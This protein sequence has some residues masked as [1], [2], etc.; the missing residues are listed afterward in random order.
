M[1]KG[2]RVSFYAYPAHVRQV[3]EWLISAYKPTTTIIGGDARAYIDGR[4]A[5]IIGQWLLDQLSASRQFKQRPIGIIL[6]RAA[7]KWLARNLPSWKRFS[8][9]HGPLG[10]FGM[11]ARRAT[12]SRIGRPVLTTAQMR[13]RLS[14]G[15]NIDERHAWRLRAR[16]KRTS[17][18]H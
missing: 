16:L 3:G 13:K 5:Q 2:R 17:L 4:Y 6:P 18:G 11:A 10:S 14:E 1:S 7:L 9:L 8:I 15:Y 12:P